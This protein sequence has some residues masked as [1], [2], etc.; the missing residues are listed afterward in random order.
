MQSI[1]LMTAIVAQVDVH[2]EFQKLAVD[3]RRT[4]KRLASDIGRISARASRGT[5]G[6]PRRRRLF[7]VRT[8]GTFGDDDSRSTN[9]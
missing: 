9:R 1:E 7:R 3:P 8:D 5:L 2:A 6:R 4:L